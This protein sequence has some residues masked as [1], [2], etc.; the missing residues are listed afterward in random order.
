[1]K[2][3]VEISDLLLR[4]AKERCAERGISLRELIESSLRAMLDPPK[5]KSPF[6]LKPFGFRGE[7]QIQ[8]DWATIRELAYTGRGGAE[9][10]DHNT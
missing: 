1:M 2:T 10:G 8:H 3:T 7:G 4:R 5:A 6:R 9:T